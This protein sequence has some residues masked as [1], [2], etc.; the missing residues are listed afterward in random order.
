[1][2]EQGGIFTPEQVQ[3]ASEDPLLEEKLA[4]RRWDDQAKVPGLRVPE[5]A[6][7]EE[8]VIQ[9]LDSA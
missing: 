2:K 6:T 8:M 5:L 4:V 3:E 1:M 9:C 7:Y